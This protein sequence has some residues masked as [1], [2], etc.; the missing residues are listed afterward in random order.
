[1][2][3]DSTWDCKAATRAQLPSIGVLTGGFSE[4]ELTETGA[5]IVFESVERLREHLKTTN[6]QET[7]SG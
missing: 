5:T 7:V 1:M 2:I 4:Q 6:L 3:G